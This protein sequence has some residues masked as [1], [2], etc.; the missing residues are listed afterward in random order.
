MFRK[1]SI[2]YKKQVRAEENLDE[3]WCYIGG[4]A[5]KLFARLAH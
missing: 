5:E 3:I 4:I 1:S 2:S